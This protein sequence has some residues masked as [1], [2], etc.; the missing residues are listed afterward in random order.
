MTQTLRQLESTADETALVGN[1]IVPC[2]NALRGLQGR[3][4]AFLR[5]LDTARRVLEDLRPSI[6]GLCR[7]F[8][9]TELGTA[10]EADLSDWVRRGLDTPPAFERTR[11]AYRTPAADGPTFFFGPV[12]AADGSASRDTF[13]E[14]FLAWREEPEECRRVKEMF[15]P[16]DFRCQPARVL[17]A[18]EGIVSGNAIVFS[19]QNIAGR[20]AVARPNE[21]LCFF[22]KFSRIYHEYTLPNIRRL[23]GDAD[24]LFGGETWL[25]G[26]LGP[27]DCYRARCVVGYLRQHFSRR[28]P[29]L[30]ESLRSRFNWFAGL[31]EEIK[32]DCDT[33]MACLEAG[34]P[35]GREA[36]QFT[37]FERLL[38]CPRPLE[39]TKF[40]DAGSGVFL[41]EWFYAKDAIGV[42]GDGRLRIGLE[43]VCDALRALIE[44][45]ESL[46]RLSNDAV[47]IAGAKALVRH[48][49]P[50]GAHGE[51]FALP[52]AYRS[53]AGAPPHTDALRFDRLE[54]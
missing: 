31:L 15:S 54:Y 8:G 28:G 48:H 14:A 7:R 36:F 1:L 21:D 12:C 47:Y 51:R 53:L 11:A 9:Q 3:S 44:A 35:F 27:E 17:R 40:N 33:A 2:T 42:T 19:P 23:F 34:V 41:F 13:I 6:T 49:L 38:R 39:A 30:G 24:A 18:T 26:D 50:E 25:S 22:N 16:T 37:L 20:G 52:E 46:G 10:L 45:T 5:Q 32:V 4:G 43:A 29:R